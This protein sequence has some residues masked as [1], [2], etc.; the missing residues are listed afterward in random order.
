MEANMIMKIK[1]ISFIAILMMVHILVPMNRDIQLCKQKQNISFK[2]LHGF[3]CIP[4][5]KGKNWYD[6]LTKN[7]KNKIHK[8]I[9]YIEKDNPC[10]AMLF[11]VAVTFPSDIQQKLALDFCNQNEKVAKL[12]LRMPIVDVLHNYALMQEIFI[13]K[14]KVLLKEELE[15]KRDIIFKYAREIDF[16]KEKIEHKEILS[17]KDLEIIAPISDKFYML[18]LWYKDYQYYEK[19]TIDNYKENFKNKQLLLY[20]FILASYIIGTFPEGFDRFLNKN[21]IEFNQLAYNFNQE[22]DRRYQKTGLQDIGMSRVKLINTYDIVQN[23]FIF[24]KGLAGFVTF[25]FYMV[26]FLTHTH[27]YAINKLEDIISPVQLTIMICLFMGWCKIIPFFEDLSRENPFLSIIYMTGWYIFLSCCYNTYTMRSIC[28]ES[29]R[30]D[31]VSE[32]LQ[33]SDIVII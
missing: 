27:S 7:Q 18:S 25:V 23:K 24:I 6:A 2:T 1:Q 10:L 14:P 32:L 13:E 4:L 12:F 19:L 15:P 17:K 3:P 33:R 31:K 16:F 30:L 21:K 5:C 9:A 28:K 11:N 22:V 29:I 20:P 26:K 8:R